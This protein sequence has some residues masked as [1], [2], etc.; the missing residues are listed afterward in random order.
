MRIYELAVPII[1]I[2]NFI[3]EEKKNETRDHIR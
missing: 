2:M 1:E 3:E